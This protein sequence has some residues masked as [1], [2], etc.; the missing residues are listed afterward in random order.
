MN[1]YGRIVYEASDPYMPGWD[2][3][4][5]GIKQSTGAYVWFLKG[6]DKN[7]KIIE[8]KGTVVLIR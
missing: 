6:S 4:Y 5:L 8:K 7:G 1:R 3:T 2:G